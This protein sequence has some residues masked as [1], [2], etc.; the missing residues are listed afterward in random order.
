MGE[1][2][3]IKTRL[4]KEELEKLNKIDNAL[5]YD[6][7]GKLVTIT[8]SFEF[9]I[10]TS[11]ESIIQSD[12]LIDHIQK[13]AMD[14]R[15]E[16]IKHMLLQAKNLYDKSTVYVPDNI[17]KYYDPIINKLD[18]IMEC[19]AKCKEYRD[20]IAHSPPFVH[21]STNT[22]LTELHVKWQH[23]SSRRFKPNRHNSLDTTLIEELVAQI[24]PKTTTLN[25]VVHY[26]VAYCRPVFLIKEVHYEK[27]GVTSS[28]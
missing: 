27:T 9:T 19:Y 26:I 14:M 2:N 6:A 16:F 7:I 1:N 4:P 3:Q 10:N 13:L 11:I 24:G 17:T 28:I 12:K 15:I 22:E 8:G 21:I 18:E 23:L 25:D 20:L 5:P